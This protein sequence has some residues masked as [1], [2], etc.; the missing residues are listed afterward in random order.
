MAKSAAVPALVE[1]CGRPGPEELREA[2]AVA[3]WD[4]AY[5][6]AAGREA[7]ARAG[8]EGGG[9]LMVAG[10]CWEMAVHGPVDSVPINTNLRSRLWTATGAVPWLAQ[11]LLFGGNGAKEAAAACLAELAA[12]GP[13]VQGAIREAGAVPLLESLQKSGEPERA[14]GLMLLGWQ[15][16][17]AGGDGSV[18]HAAWVDG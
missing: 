2:A 4:L 18:L 1:L 7:I 6:S 8:E 5:D 15:W 9:V 11:L 10:D 3:L 12:V 17:A 13:A 16:R 14:G